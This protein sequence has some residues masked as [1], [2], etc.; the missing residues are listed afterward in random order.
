MNY[1]SFWSRG[2]ENN[3]SPGIHFFKFLFL[4]EMLPD[5]TTCKNCTIAWVCDS[6]E[7]QF[8][9]VGE[10]HFLQIRKL[11]GSVADPTQDLLSD[12]EMLVVLAL[13]FQCF[14]AWTWIKYI[15]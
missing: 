11:F 7:D 1:E 9:N 14:C 13:S 15:V 12:L 8:C 4:F 5:L 10:E 3:R 6:A 2:R